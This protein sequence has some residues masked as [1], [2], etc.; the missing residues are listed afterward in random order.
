MEQGVVT[1]SVC[2]GAVMIAA[3]AVG[4]ITAPLGAIGLVFGR[5]TLTLRGLNTKA[6]RLRVGGLE[7]DH[8]KREG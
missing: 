2:W 6:L 4:L 3:F 7:Y 1:R 8:R 5:C